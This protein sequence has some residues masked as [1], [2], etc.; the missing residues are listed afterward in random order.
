MS[1]STVTS[2]SWHT[3]AERRPV[4]H[5]IHLDSAASSRSSFACLD[6]T[7]AYARAEAEQGA[8]IL[9][10]RHADAIAALRADLALLLGV[11]ADGVAFVNGAAGALEA[12]LR[13]AP[14]A[15]GDEVIVVPSEWGPNLAAFETAGFRLQFAAV[16]GAGVIDVAA[17]DTQLR[18]KP[19]AL[20]HI[21][22]QA[23]HRALRQ[24]AA[25]IIAVCDVHGVPVWLDVAQALGHDA[26]AP[27]AAVVYGTSRKWLTGPRGIGF[28]GISANYRER[29]RLDRVPPSM[30]PGAPPLDAIEQHEAHH[31]GRIGLVESIAEYL[32]IGQEAVH[33]RLT[34]VGQAVRAAV[35]ELAGWRSVDPVDAPGAISALEPRAGQ[36]VFEV[37]QRL[38]AEHGIVTTA[39]ALARAPRE[40]TVPTLRVSPHVDMSTEQLDALV[41]ALAAI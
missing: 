41:R 27:G 32:E 33:T 22:P 25:E 3:W 2:A 21:T 24:P 36:D 13:V 10:E 8:Y 14:V 31:A 4:P 26:V 37:R 38:I 15:A 28:V 39:C 6:A 19:P 7:A 16:D 5:V 20:V 35:A 9:A 18:R 17:L 12:A 40:M 23:S 29:L 30:R 34:A 11:D 1:T